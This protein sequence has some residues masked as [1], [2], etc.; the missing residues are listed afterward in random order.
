MAHPARPHA[1]QYLPDARPR[2][3]EFDD[4]CGDGAGGVVDAGFVGCGDGGVGGLGAHVFLFSFIFFC[5]VCVWMGGRERD[6]EGL[7]DFF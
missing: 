4:F 1:D 7:R 5:C 6:C 3:G 2:R